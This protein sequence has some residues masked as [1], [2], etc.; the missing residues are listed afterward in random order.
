MIS[1]LDDLNS[2]IKTRLTEKLPTFGGAVGEGAVTR[3][4]HHRTPLCPG[5][6]ITPIETGTQAVIYP[7][8]YDND[9]RLIG[10]MRLV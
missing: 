3:P 4:A 8:R 1:I 6:V 10:K 2:F 9:A 5:P 7:M